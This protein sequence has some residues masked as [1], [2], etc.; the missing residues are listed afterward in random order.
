MMRRVTV[1]ILLCGVAL[2]GVRQ[3][4]AVPAPFD[5][6]GPSLSVNVTR[7]NQTLPISEVPNFQPGDRLSIK[8]RLPADQA[9]H[10]LLVT[11][12]LRGPTNPPPQSWFFMC[13]VW[14]TQCAQQGLSLVV[15]K[16]A[17][18]VL[19]FLAPETGGDYKTLRNA[20][21]GK[22][23]A[24]VRASQDLNQ[25]A[26]DRARLEVYLSSLRSLDAGDQ[27]RLKEVAPLLARSLALKV[28]EKC[29]DRMPSLQAACLMQG[30][31]SLILNDGHSKSI[32]EALTSGP[33]TDLVMEASYT[34]QLSY[35]YYS[36]YIAS[37][38]D[39][40]RLLD[41]LHTAQYQY[42][43]ALATFRADQ[44]ALTLNTPPSF[45]DPQS[46]LVAALPAVDSA[47]L[48]PLH[49]VNPHE[50]YCASRATLLL[51][52]EGAP[53]AFAGKYAHDLVLRI[54]GKDGKNMD[55]PARADAQQGGIVVDALTLGADVLAAHI[56]AS[57]HGA[58]GFDPYDGPTF[59]LTA[60]QS[61]AWEVATPDAAPL[62]AGH[63]ATLRLKSGSASCARAL[64]VTDGGGRELKSSWHLD[65]SSQIELKLP[66]QEATPGDYSIVVT[67]Y[68]GGEARR[69]E[70]HSYP[71]AGHLDGFS[72]HVGD[73]Q[74]TLSGSRLEQ[75]VGLRLKGLDF[76][77][78]AV[79]TGHNGEELTLATHDDAATSS[80]R[81]GET[82]EARVTLA[83]GRSVALKVA[84]AAPRPRVSLLD[85]AVIKSAGDTAGGIRL[86]DADELPAGARLRFSLRAET[87]VMRA[88]DASV[89][90]AVGEEEPA[91]RLT[92]AN[93]TF[94]VENERVGV[95]TL[96]TASA[97]GGAAFGPLRYR[98]VS[99]GAAGDWY[100][101]ATLVRL[102]VLKELRC[103]AASE[104]SC[105]LLGTNLFLLEAVSATPQ[106]ERVVSVPD[107][108]PGDALPVPHPS[109]GLLYLRLRDNPGVVNSATLRVDPVVQP[110]PRA[111]EP[112][113]APKAQEL[114]SQDATQ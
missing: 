66:A 13:E 46:V 44:V 107:G 108:F 49:A 51:P 97:F 69:L 28:D 37:V 54:K 19:V 84:V 17:Q 80:W 36:P 76:A 99:G 75:V 94:I 10:Y 33:A 68:G 55:L 57:L 38:F 50:V 61:Q 35:G 74:G 100:P 30:Q 1:L 114:A 81:A 23:G 110:D 73:A 91:V 27:A 4:L 72:I 18:Q 104:G 71:E 42:I 70:L 48:P 65:E 87:S 77:P 112:H 106:F 14:K 26:L 24:F 79:V 9:A 25:A 64:T 88:R 109:Q 92:A 62:I 8:P 60:A 103:S 96:D 86:T 47:R 53:L 89:E 83:D 58:W 52:V 41:S 11:A 21:R 98:M 45:H 59:E 12:F 34:P 67:Q 3:A 78:G 113:A 29:L 6:V 93:G 7:G 2:V 22:P 102:P 85:K 5:L 31:D 43:P 15:P 63:D 20:V 40:G 16:D 39:I 32:V 56:Q 90:V 101:L 105:T 95:A 82:A 111:P